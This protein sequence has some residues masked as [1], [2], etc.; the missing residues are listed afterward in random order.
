MN[1]KIASNKSIEL[2]KEL[3]D[4]LNK[5]EVKLSNVLPQSS[6][7]KKDVVYES[8]IEKNKFLHYVYSVDDIDSQIDFIYEEIKLL[9]EFIF[10]ELKKLKKYKK[11]ED[12][13]IYYKN[14]PT[15]KYTWKQISEEVN[16]SQT[17]CREIYR[18]F[19]QK[20]FID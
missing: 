6:K 9:N 16:Y 2:E 20:R 1:L 18:R 3:E 17:Q 10:K 15:K 12:L 4:L 5:K 7:I 11:I 14:N 13:I 8:R 19:K